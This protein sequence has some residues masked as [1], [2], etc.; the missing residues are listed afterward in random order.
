MTPSVALLQALSIPLFCSS[1][2]AQEPLETFLDSARSRALDVREAEAAVEQ[3]SSQVAEARARLLPALTGNVAYQRNEPEVVVG[4]PTGMVDGMGNPITREAV[5]TAAD[6][7]TASA[8]L[9]VPLVDLSSWAGFFQT[10]AVEDATRAQFDLAHQNVSVAVV[11]IWHQLVAQRALVHAAERNAE[12][13]ERSRDAAAARVEVGASPQLELA[14]A[15]AELA[16]AQQNLAE[17][18]L[19]SRLAARNLEDLTGLRPSE[20]EAE[21]ADD[22]AAEPPIERF[23][24]N[25]DDL[26]AVRAAH[27]LERASDIARNG[28]WLALLPTISASATARYSNASGFGQS[29]AYSVGVSATWILDFARPARVEAASA[30]LDVARVRAER[31]SQQAETAIYDAWERVE[32]LRSSASAAQAQLDASQRAAEDARARFE[33]GAGTQLDQITAERDLFQAEVARIQALANLRVARAVLR[34]RSGIDEP[35]R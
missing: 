20:A 15:Q 16:R 25:A 26:P 33:S 12:T 21:L 32:S 18:R 1:A 3:A 13:T 22:L 4:I 9:S 23:A 14:R 6:Q 29:D 24:G 5:V 8:T 31:A 27:H 10:Q 7:L 2:L 19:Q 11:Q 30:A 35:V 17:A 28:A 34:I